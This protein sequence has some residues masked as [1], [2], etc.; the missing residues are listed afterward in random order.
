MFY[1]LQRLLKDLKICG[2]FG[3]PLENKYGYNLEGCYKI[4]FGNKKYRI[5]YTLEDDNISIYIINIDERKDL[6]VYRDVHVEF[7]IYKTKKH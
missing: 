7:T 3:M 6:K 1:E 4:Y 5:V 2:S